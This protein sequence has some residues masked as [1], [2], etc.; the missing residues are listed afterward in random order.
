MTIRADAVGRPIGPLVTDYTWKDVI[1]Y[2]LAVG[3]GFSELAYCHEKQLKVLPGFPA[4]ATFDLF[5]A[6]CSEAG[7]DPA[8][9]LHGEQELFLTGAIPSEGSL[10]ATGRITGIYDK[11]KTIGALVVAEGDI[12]HSDGQKLLK[13]RFSIFSRRDGGCGGKKGPGWPHSIP[14]RAPDWR[15]GQKPP[16]NGPLLYRLTGDL[17][18][19]HAEPEFARAAGFKGPIMHGLCTLGY[20]CRALLQS[21]RPGRP[22]SARYLACRFSGPLYPGEPIS[23]EIWDT[24]PGEAAWRTVN[25]ET[26]ATILDRGKFHYTPS[27]GQRP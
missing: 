5:W 21:L 12:R 27:E 26:G 20:A 16:S 17:F 11:G 6:V 13:S 23:T 3:A 18:P 7:V 15:I 8:G 25:T 1:L 24:A 14:D 19:L 9:V 10:T 4:A 22:E 2:A